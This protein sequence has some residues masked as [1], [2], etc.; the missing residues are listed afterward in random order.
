MKFRNY[1]L[2]TSFSLVAT[3][4][5]ALV[6]TGRL[7][8]ASP[9][10]YVAALAGAWWLERNHPERLISRK[11]AALISAIAIPLAAGDIL[12]L[13]RN[14]F[15]GL[16]RFALFLA[17]VKMYQKKD[18]SDW[19]WL[20]GLAFGQLL[21]A[22]SLTIDAT[23]LVSFGLFLFFLLTTL[24]AFEIER[25]HSKL[26]RVEEEQHAIRGDH[27]R[28]LRRGWFV[29]GIGLVQIALV[30]VLA[31][32]IFFVLPRF[33]GGYLGSAYSQTQTL[34]GFSD[35][36]K[37]GDL[38]NIRLNRTIVMYVKLDRQPS[39]PLRWRGIA[40]DEFDAQ[41]GAWRTVRPFRRTI[42]DRVPGIPAYFDIEPL[43]PGTVATDLLEQTIYLEP[44]SNVTLFAAPRAKRI[45]N[46]P[47]E[48]G[49][50]GAGSLRGP[51]H[52]GSRLSYIVTSDV[53]G[54]SVDE[55]AKDT[56]TDYP[57]E[58][59]SLN[60]QSPKLDPRVA[61]LSREIIG[62]AVTPYD[63]ARRIET[64]LKNQFTY[65]LSLTRK[66]TSIDPVSD[67]L[68]N[69]QEGHC[70]YFAT[71]MAVMLRSVG[72]PTRVVNGFQMG[73]FN[74]ISETYTVRQSDAHAW[75]EVYFMGSDE[76][77]EF[78][79]TPAAGLNAY[80]VDVTTDFRRS[81]E[82]L[83]LIWIRY[84]V[85]LDTQE[86]LTIF[87]SIQSGLA[88]VK[89][90]VTS[91]ISSIRRW[92][93]S[94]V[95]SGSDYVSVSNV[96]T[97][98][99]AA[100]LGIGVLSIAGMLLHGRGWNLGGL[101][102]PVW[103][104]RAWWR[105]GSRPPERTAILF[106][107]QMAAMLARHGIVRQSSLTPR[108][109]AGECGID[110]VRQITEQYHRVRFGKATIRSV[111]HDVAEALG[112]LATKLRHQPRAKQPARPPDTDHG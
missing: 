67:F 99:V 110:E 30:A 96:L 108:E 1:F 26:V 65:T 16:A 15:L 92:F 72:V 104:W 74:P 6:L 5:V 28:P 109:F 70:E 32:P 64:F 27:P 102:L 87:R 42:V 49:V 38:E 76:W 29:S 4:F 23:F 45:D 101:V 46:A 68:L 22:A 39:R 103:R 111:E 56:A 63:K 7:D 88:N 60:L 36:V 40:L 100:M 21:L 98:I 35:R 48:V 20:Y 50:D 34:S 95:D 25:S 33:G 18:D 75:V 59:R 91:K 80:D 81:I 11:R 69:V 106:Y 94:L 51:R 57:E 97:G 8:I 12:L 93:S 78:D 82:A 112:R 77:V 105:R 61:E 41:R 9:V 83:Q 85:A 90:W 52:D 66:D 10:V 17:A 31:I 84:V 79:P 14:P 89:A 53:T 62:D 71:S 37:L 86:Q 19:V 13:S 55:L 47:R 3:G 43:S 58:I 44:M 54:P 24:S 2:F 73:E 107:E